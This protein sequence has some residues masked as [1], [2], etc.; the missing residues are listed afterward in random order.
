MI[1]KMIVLFW[2]LGVL[3]GCSSNGLKGIAESPDVKVEG[4]R[5]AK[6]SFTS[7]DA[8]LSL[9][10]RNPNS[11]TIPLRGL[12]YAL[13]LNNV[14]VAQ[15]SLQQNLSVAAR[16]TRRVEIPVS[17]KLIELIQTVPS[18]VRSRNFTYQLKGNTHFPFINIPF[19]RVG[20]VGQ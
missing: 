10:I 8:I 16:Q 1:K 2:F 15:G 11:F 3:T 13:A 6:L 20:R 14:S 19:S 9:R 12:D 17:F 18:I 4:V 7:A 5:L